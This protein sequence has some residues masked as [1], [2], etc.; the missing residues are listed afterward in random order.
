MVATIT[1]VSAARKALDLAHLA[2]CT[3]CLAVCPDVQEKVITRNKEEA[4]GIIQ[5]GALP[6]TGWA[7]VLVV[8]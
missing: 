1:K 2:A 3:A 4:L 8:L 6:C 7:R 5:V